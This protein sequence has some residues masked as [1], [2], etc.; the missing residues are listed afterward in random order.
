MSIWPSD[1]RVPHSVA[2][3]PANVAGRG[4]SCIRAFVHS[5]VRRSTAG[6]TGKG[7]TRALGGTPAADVCT[8]SRWALMSAVR[9]VSARSADWRAGLRRGVGEDF[10]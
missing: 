1:A 5:R 4:L 10:P 2:N 8:L 9:N 7:G 6:R 3:S